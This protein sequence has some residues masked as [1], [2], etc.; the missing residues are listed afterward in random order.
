MTKSLES[1]IKYRS[2]LKEIVSDINVTEIFI[3][4]DGKEDEDAIVF[5]AQLIA[6]RGRRGV[7]EAFFQGTFKKGYDKIKKKLVQQIPLSKKTILT[8][9]FIE[10]ISEVIKKNQNLWNLRQAT[11]PKA[12]EV[13]Q[14]TPTTP[15]VEFPITPG[16]IEMTTTTEPKPNTRNYSRRQ[17]LSGSV[18]EKSETT[19]RRVKGKAF[20]VLK[21]AFNCDDNQ[22]SE[23]A[24]LVCTPHICKQKSTE[25]T[26][27]HTSDRNITPKSQLRPEC[28]QK[29]MKKITT[30]TEDEKIAVVE[31]LANCKEK[32]EIADG[33]KHLK[34]IMAPRDSRY[35]S[36]TAKKLGEWTEA[37]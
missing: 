29:V 36:I 1:C 19:Q 13:V 14:N 22:V 6:E 15:I 32:G 34:S 9:E 26:I 11:F 33:L 37:G 28:L 17:M 3:R 35:L 10:Y 16:P 23:I 27:I 18:L 31:S 7:M 25:N 12:K 20:D 8:A 4:T 21:E 24:Q 30:F 2:R 5:W